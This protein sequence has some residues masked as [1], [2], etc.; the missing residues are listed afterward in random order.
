LTYEYLAVICTA[1]DSSSDSIVLEGYSETR[2]SLT[3]HAM[4]L[5]ISLK[6]SLIDYVVL[7]PR[8]AFVSA[9]GEAGVQTAAWVSL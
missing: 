5:R 3:V 4:T 9:K 7:L 6:D 8:D 1:A 2:V